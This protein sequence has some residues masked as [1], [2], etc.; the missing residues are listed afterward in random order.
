MHENSNHS[1]RG[2][3]AILL[4]LFHAGSALANASVAGEEVVAYESK[5]FALGVGLGIVEF[6]TNAKVTAKKTGGSRYIDLE[7][8][9]GLPDNDQVNTIYG[10]YKFNEKHSLVFGYFSIER[11]SSILNFSEDF[12]DIIVVKADVSI[13]DNSRF[14][15]LGY[16]YTLFDDDRSDVTLIFGLKSLDLRLR[17]EARGE[18]TVNG[19][20]R[21]RV[22]IT[23]ADV[24]APLPLLGLN[25]GFNFTPKWGISTRIGLVGGTYQDVSASVVETSINSRYQFAKHAGFLLG[26]TYFDANVDIDDDDEVTEVSYGYTGAFVGLHFGF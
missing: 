25:F 24:L 5:K 3:I 12:N 16:G 10:A 15:N 13:E 7:G 1:A 14:Y 20:T 22:E 2:F 18:I 23:E 6:D 9:L 26:L 19:E 11:K 4:L 17:A 21:S 8:N